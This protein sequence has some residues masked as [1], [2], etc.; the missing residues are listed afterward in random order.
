METATH[1]PD[2]SDRLR[3]VTWGL[4]IEAADTIDYLRDE[5]YAAQLEFAKLNAQV[6]ELRAQLSEPRRAR[7]TLVPLDLTPGIEQSA[8]SRVYELAD[9]NERLR[10]Q[11]S[12]YQQ[13]FRDGGTD[14][15]WALLQH[16]LDA[17]EFG[18]VAS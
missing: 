12:E 10:A 13:A 5:L 14:A 9:D 16:R 4:S 11:V 3:A 17:G 7:G 15:L 1:T 18:E 2:L 8:V 6:A